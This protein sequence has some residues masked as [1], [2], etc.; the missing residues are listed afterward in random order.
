MLRRS[1]QRLAVHPSVPRALH[2][3]APRASSHT[4]IE[5]DMIPAE[6]WDMK[7]LSSKWNRHALGKHY[8]P[9]S[10]NYG[11]L[12]P[13]GSTIPTTLFWGIPHFFKCIMGEKQFF[14]L[15]M[16]K[17]FIIFTPIFLTYCILYEGHLRDVEFGKSR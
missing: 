7:N 16:L 2:T 15:P 9:G 4:L 5:K 8:G 11:L 12:T 1:V 3:T 10:H 17:H 14:G 13:P 6:T